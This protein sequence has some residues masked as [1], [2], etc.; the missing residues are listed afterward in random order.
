MQKT[1]EKARTGEVSSVFWGQPESW[2]KP[3]ILSKVPV[4]PKPGKAGPSKPPQELPPALIFLF[5]PA[6]GPVT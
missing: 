5:H 1:R 3:C 6:P 4:K 2:H